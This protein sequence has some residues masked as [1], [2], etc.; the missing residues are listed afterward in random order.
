VTSNRARIRPKFR[1]SPRLNWAKCRHWSSSLASW[2][3]FKNCSAATSIFTYQQPQPTAA[4]S[5][6]LYSPAIIIIITT[7]KFAVCLAFFLLGLAMVLADGSAAT[8]TVVGATATGLVASPGTD[9][10]KTITVTSTKTVEQNT[11]VRLLR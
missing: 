1:N 8:A 6:A 9:V 3:V 5:R 4:L 7:M 2:L 11:N 10:T